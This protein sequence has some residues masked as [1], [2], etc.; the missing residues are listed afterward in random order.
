MSQT[1]AAFTAVHLP[2]S[3]SSSNTR[4][5]RYP[6]I[7]R[8]PVELTLTTFR[9]CSSDIKARLGLSHTCRHWMAIVLRTSGLWTDIRIRINH[10]AES[11]QFGNLISLLEIQ[12][13]R[14]AGMPLDVVWKSDQ[15]SAFDPRL[16]N[17]LR[18][19]G[20]FSQWRTLQMRFQFPA[21]N[22]DDVV[23]F[24]S[25]D[26]FSNLE[27]IVIFSSVRSSIVEVL[28]RTTTSKL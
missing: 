18:R 3:I 22:P 16:M 27:S 2:P 25:G 14:A 19:K 5:V 24:H 12:L 28:N 9:Y 11:R 20:P 26:A 10:P 15:I 4:I 8:L 21:F 7:L 17:L 6:P 23:L 1:Q 13:E